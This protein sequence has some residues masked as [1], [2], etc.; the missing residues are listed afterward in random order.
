[1]SISYA[2]T[3]TAVVTAPRSPRALFGLLCINIAFA[4]TSV[5]WWTMMSLFAAEP[6][7]WAT[8]TGISSSPD[9]LEYPFSL[10][11]MVPVASSIAAW[12]T[13]KGGKK[14]TAFNLACFPLIFLGLVFGWYYLAPPE[15]R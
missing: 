1:M 3:D 15:W 5:F 12:L 4:A 13:H 2:G 7:K 6:I 11:W 10:L 8:W 9:L 14:R